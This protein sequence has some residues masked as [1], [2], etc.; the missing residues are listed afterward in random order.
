[1]VNPTVSPAEYAQHHRWTTRLRSGHLEFE[2]CPCCGDAK[3]HFRMN[4]ESGC[5]DC[6]KCNAS[7]NLITLMRQVGDL[8]KFLPNAPEIKK[9]VPVSD[10]RIELAHSALLVSPE[11]M[12]HFQRR[13]FTIDTVRRFKL[14]YQVHE[15]IGPCIGYPIYADGKCWVIKW[16]AVAK[17]DFIREPAKSVSPLFNQDALK[18]HPEI[19]LAEGESDAIAMIQ[20]GYENVVGTILGAGSSTAEWVREVK[21]CKRVYIAYDPDDAGNDGAEKAA[22]AIGRHKCYR[23]KFPQGLDANDYINFYGAV[24]LKGLLSEATPMGVPAVLDAERVYEQYQIH[25]AQEGKGITSGISWWD[26]LVGPFRPSNLYILAGY[27]GIG[28]STLAAQV[29]WEIAK[30]GRIVWY[31]CLE[32]SVLEVFKL[33]TEHIL[34]KREPTD[35]DYS[36]AYCVIQDTGFRFFDPS[37]A[38]IKATDQFDF[39]AEAVKENG[40]EFLV[41]DN[42]NYLSRTDRNSNEF[43]GVM[44]K[45]AKQISVEC[46]IPVMMLHHPR[47]PEGEEKEPDNHSLKG[48][49][50]IVNDASA[51]IVV[52]RKPVNGT[53]PGDE[54][55]EN[56]TALKVTKSRWKK[57]GRDNIYYETDKANF[58]QATQFDYQARATSTTKSKGKSGHQEHWMEKY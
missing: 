41:I 26:N 47:K 25:R 34:K 37:V 13:G 19:I 52:H 50:S 5:W 18:K 22:L 29:T 58:R 43:E 12:A 30:K 36:K 7:G 21:K 9:S 40:V 33:V 53:E 45:R 10:K 31:Y 27:A 35:E 23:V 28:K 39:I 44:S 32:M 20:A 51:V 16:R 1:M 15:H 38:S 3:Y 56:L 49:S 54:D 42:F 46:K 8:T 55:R 14:G 2:T 4:A 17:K 11:G 6:K 24:G 48:S 57:G